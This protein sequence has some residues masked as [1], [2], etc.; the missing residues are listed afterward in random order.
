MLN[1][2][3]K[4]KWGLYPQLIFKNFNELFEAL[5]EI[6]NP[7]YC[8]IHFEENTL[9]GS[10]TDVF[11]VVFRINP[12]YCIITAFRRC[13]LYGE[14]INYTSTTFIY[15]V[16]FSIASVFIGFYVFYKNQDKF[17]LHI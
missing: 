6:S 10:R 4:L 1:P 3:L 11:R 5:G 15:T 14:S 9:N 8:S 12:L 13:V 2:D 16:I 17:I 7:K